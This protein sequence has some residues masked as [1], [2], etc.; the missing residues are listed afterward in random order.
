MSTALQKTTPGEGPMDANLQENQVA[1]PAPAALKQVAG[2]LRFD[3]TMIV[4]CSWLLTGV[5]IDGWAHNHFYIIDTFFTPW[6]AVL[7]SGFLSI[8]IFLAIVLV[9]N[10]RKGYLW[11]AAVPPGYG[12]SLLGI[13]IFGIGGVSDFFWHTLFGFDVELATLLSPTHLMLAAGGLLIVSGPLRAAWLRPERNAKLRWFS[14]LPLILSLTFVLGALAFMTSFAHPFVSIA[15]MSTFQP[16]GTSNY[17]TYL[18]DLVESWGVLSI[19]LQSGLLIGT[20]L[21][22]IRRQRAPLGTFTIMLSVSLL[23]SCV[24]LGNY[25]LIPVAILSGLAADIFYRL[26]RP[27]VERVGALRLFVFV[28]PVCLFLLYFL[29][30]R[31]FKNVW[32]PLTIWSG[33]IF[34]SGI[35]GLLLS[36]L[37]VPPLRNGAKPVPLFLTSFQLTRRR[38]LVGLA[39]LGLAAGGL[40]AAGDL[41]LHRSSALGPGFPETFGGPTNFYATGSQAIVNVPDFL[42]QASS[43]LNSAAWSPNGKLIASANSD[44][45][46]QIWSASGK[47]GAVM[48]GAALFTYRKHSKAATDLAWS[49]DGKYIA[50][51]SEDGTVQMWHVSTG[52]SLFTYRGHSGRVFA[53]AWSPD[54]SQ[55]ASAGEDKTVH[56]WHAATGAD[57]LIYREHT[58]AVI[59]LAW[60]P[61]STRIASAG[62]KGSALVWDVTTATR[63][64]AFQ[65]DDTQGNTTDVVWSPDG[66][67]IATARS[68]LSIWNASNGTQLFQ[69]QDMNNDIL[70]VAWSPNGKRFIT[71]QA[72][73]SVYIW[74]SFQSQ[75]AT[76]F[77][78]S[79]E[80]DIKYGG[81]ALLSGGGGGVSTTSFLLLCQ[82]HN[83]T[84]NAVGWSS[85]SRHAVSA[86]IDSTIQVWDT[87]VGNTQIIYQHNFA[88]ADWS[89]DG[90]S[91][92][93]I[94][95]KGIVEIWDAA[96]ATANVTYNKHPSKSTITCLTWSPDSQRMISASDD[97]TVLVWDTRTALTL[98]SA[99]LP[100]SVVYA[101]WLS[102]GK[103]V[104][105]I[106]GKGVVQVW[107]ATTGHVMKKYQKQ[108][109]GVSTAAWSPDEKHLA[110]V[111]QNGRAHILDALNVSTLPPLLLNL[112]G[113]TALAWSP[114][115]R[116]LASA[117]GGVIQVWDAAT[118]NITFSCQDS[119]YGTIELMWAPDGKR[120]AFTNNEGV[121]VWDVTDGTLLLTYLGLTGSQGAIFTA[122]WSPDGKRI[123][124]TSNDGSVQVWSAS[125]M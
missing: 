42:Y 97:G 19:L 103:H 11:W 16:A 28:V 117:D 122:S 48:E 83:G 47:A 43:A 33:S 41:L 6:H 73:G 59:A 110:I 100:Q 90:K 107:D 29:D 57:I 113:V 115:G 26:L 69:C 121:Q 22:I 66:T 108:D 74:T 67:Y 20:M 45:T 120:L 8:V 44:G 98:F 105:L 93:S 123:A 54:G 32:W 95:G 81:D 104:A 94:V 9:R 124:S 89:P 109:M 71:G 23:M 25:I 38:V 3:W 96:T 60:S 114:N 27:S 18:K 13:V 40:V 125:P 70:C 21:L 61:D 78:S 101:T 62:A 80:S 30:L 102:S 88:S 17:I 64:T 76:A 53:T 52:V 35:T 7:Y 46:I 2:S 112:R 75:N 14:Q 31:L 63:I 1:Q 77:S 58:E 50:S 68:T 99:K 39:G 106:D 56:I 116:Q 91:I 49:P 86:G 10:V 4:L 51:A 37:F 65:V 119:Q 5:Y 34:M 85:D 36:Y 84:V 24:L 55:L 87:F 111:D 92:A 12:L 72:D 15:A 82:G 79:G 118:G